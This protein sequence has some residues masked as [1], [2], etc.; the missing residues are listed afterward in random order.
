MKKIN[1]IYFSNTG[2]T[3]DMAQAVLKGA[4][5]DQTEV[6]L[7]AFQDATLE[8]VT[9]ADAVAMGCPACGT[10]E[11]DEEY[12]APFVE[13]LEGHVDGKEMV[14]FGS[15]GW[16]GGPWMETWEEQMKSYGAKL[17]TDSVIASEAPDNQSIEQCEAAGKALQS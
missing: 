15:Y 7:I 14:L 2:N 9:G 5:G 8:D 3:E 16:G 10:E 12:V 11:L 4:Q 6:N 1:V 13:S 17:V